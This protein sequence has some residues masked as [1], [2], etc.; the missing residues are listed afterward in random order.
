[1]QPFRRRRGVSDPS[2]LKYADNLRRCAPPNAIREL[3]FPASVVNTDARKRVAPGDRG[4]G[5]LRASL[6]RRRFEKSVVCRDVR[7]HVGLDGAASGVAGRP[8]SCSALT[9]QFLLLKLD[10]LGNPISCGTRK[11]SRSV[12]TPLAP[13]IAAPPLTGARLGSGQST[14]FLTSGH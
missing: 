2:R 5:D 7:R 11:P 6:V 12:L 14:P 4:G 1:M 10:P 9:H 8:T 13:W 3:P